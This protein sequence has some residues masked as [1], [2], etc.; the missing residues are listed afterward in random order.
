MKLKL[1][2]LFSLAVVMLTMSLPSLANDNTYYS[3]VTANV[4][5]EGKV[6]VGKGTTE[7]PVYVEGSSSATFSYT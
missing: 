6:Y 5:G 4:V 2:R 7:T 1:T 3:K